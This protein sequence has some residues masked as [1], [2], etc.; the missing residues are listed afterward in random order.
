VFP[1]IGE[2]KE[3]SAMLNADEIRQTV[4]IVTVTVV[5]AFGLFWGETYLRQRKEFLKGEEY[6]SNEDYKRAITS[7]ESALHMYTPGSGKVATAAD[8]LRTIA[9]Y[10]EGQGDIEMALIA[11]RSLRSSFYAVRSFYTPYPEVIAHCEEKIEQ[12]VRQQLDREKAVLA[13]EATALP[14][15]EM[16]SAAEGEA[17]PEVEEIEALPSD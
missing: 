1:R 10:Y 2:E 6:Y 11:Y 17:L 3:G 9:E 14:R 12:L 13:K 16:P 4:I 7:Y 15:Q 8:R 5:I